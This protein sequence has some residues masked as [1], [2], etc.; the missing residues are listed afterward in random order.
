MVLLLIGSQI[1]DAQG[2]PE[3]LIAAI[4][5]AVSEAGLAWPE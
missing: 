1:D 3:R 4:E 2:D 5:S